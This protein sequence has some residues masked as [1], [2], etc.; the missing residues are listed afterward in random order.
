M[1][2][3]DSSRCNGC[4]SCVQ[5]CPQGAIT[6]SGDLAVIDQ[7]LCIRCGSCVT[8]CPGNAISEKLPVHSPVRDTVPLYAE[9]SNGGGIMRGRG[10]IGLRHQRWGRGGGRGRGRGNPFPACRNYA[11]LPRRWWAARPGIT[12][13]S[14]TPR[15]PFI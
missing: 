9:A 8:V 12:P 4:G 7:E 14:Y 6:L 11:W 5:S 10:W 1:F 2:I 3:I 13:Y 15:G